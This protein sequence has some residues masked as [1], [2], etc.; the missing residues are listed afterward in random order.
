MKTETAKGYFED[1][2]FVNILRLFRVSPSFPFTTTET[3]PDYQ[4]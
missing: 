2:Q 4:F 1:N 3:M